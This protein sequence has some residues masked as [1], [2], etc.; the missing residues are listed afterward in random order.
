MKEWFEDW[1]D[2]IYYKALYRGR[3]EEEADRFVELLVQELKIKGDSKILDVAC[4]RGRHSVALNELGFD[5]TGTDLSFQKIKE[6]INLEN[7]KL[8]FYRHD[9]R[10]VFRI[11]YF[12]CVFNF[13]TSFGYFESVYD[14]K[15]AA[16]AMSANLK[17]NGYFV[18]DYLNAEYV[19]RNL[20][21]TDK[22]QVG[23][24][25]FIIEKS[26]EENR[27][28]KKITVI[29]KEK[30]SV[31]YEKVRM[32]TLEQMIHLFSTYSLVVEN[33]FGSYRLDPYDEINSERM[34]LVF[35]KIKN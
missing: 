17:W 25:E 21:H 34:I 30:C 24:Y 20:I 11:N 8:H 31:F 7:D 22:M 1:F 19:K 33:C 13:F 3:N 26:L 12:D 14:E 2:T 10:H 16:A 5:V 29:E 9:M 35:R 32:Y 4:G 6:L 23:E 15:N 27:I 28:S 18:I